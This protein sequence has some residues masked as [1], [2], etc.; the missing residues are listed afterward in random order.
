MEEGTM[1]YKIC[2]MCLAEMPDFSGYQIGDTLKIVE[3][4]DCGIC[5]EVIDED[6]EEHS[7]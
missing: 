4:A 5:A 1:E 3:E 7:N 6:E 2:A